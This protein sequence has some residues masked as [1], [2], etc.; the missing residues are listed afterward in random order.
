MSCACGC[1]GV[2]A[3][4][5]AYRIA[6]IDQYRIRWTAPIGIWLHPI[7]RGPIRQEDVGRIQQIPR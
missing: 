2:V 5:A 7:R 4:D 1:S 6:Q 3:M